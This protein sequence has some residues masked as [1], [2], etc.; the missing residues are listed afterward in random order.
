[1]CDYCGGFYAPFRNRKFIKGLKRS[2]CCDK[3][4]FAY[5]REHPDEFY[6][7]KNKKRDLEIVRMRKL[8]YSL[9]A[10]AFAAGVSKSTVSG[11]LYSPKSRWR[12]YVNGKN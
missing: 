4:Y 6:P 11:I 7:W 9:E 5:R 12:R 10:L 1:M 3:H 2:F 8:G